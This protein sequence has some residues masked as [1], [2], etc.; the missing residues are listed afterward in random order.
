MPR[1]TWKVTGINKHYN[2]LQPIKDTVE[3]SK[4]DSGLALRKARVKWPKAPELAVARIVT[5]KGGDAS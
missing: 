5:D 2:K 3:T 1:Y 4:L